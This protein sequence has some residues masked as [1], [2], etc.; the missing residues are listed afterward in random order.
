MV[1]ADRDRY[2]KP[3]DVLVQELAG[4]A[5]LLSLGHGFYY[6][7]DEVGFRMYQSIT[8]SSSLKIAYENLLREYEVAPVQLQQDFNKL[9]DELISSN[10]I[11]KVDA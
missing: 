4:E 9:V 8:T 3:D 11:I 2:I 10:L 6:G 5:V 7:L 1:Y